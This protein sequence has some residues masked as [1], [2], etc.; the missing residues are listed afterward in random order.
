MRELLSRKYGLQT[1][2]NRLV[3]V[4]YR[5]I[6]GETVIISRQIRSVKPDM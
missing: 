4:M 6:K 3:E 1:G 2:S 5:F